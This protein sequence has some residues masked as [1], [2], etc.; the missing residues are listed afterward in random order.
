MQWNAVS[1]RVLLAL[2]MVQKSVSSIGLPGMFLEVECH[3]N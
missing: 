3:G 1:V 2:E